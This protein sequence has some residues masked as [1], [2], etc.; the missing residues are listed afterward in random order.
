MTQ[1]A[2]G[3]LPTIT[4]VANHAGV[5]RATTSRALSNYGVVN[6]ATRAR[7]LESA[8]E[9]GYVPNVLARSMRAGSTH[10][11]GLIIAEVGLSVFDLAMRS[12]IESARLEDYQVLV[13]N[14]NEDLRAERTSVR[15]MLEKQVDGLIVVPSSV[16]ELEFLSKADLKGKPVTLL[17]RSLDSLGIASVTAD[18]LQG[19]RDAVEHM[20]ALGHT[21][22]GLIVVTAN[23]SGETGERP[24]GLITTIHDRVEGYYRAMADAGIDIDPA[25]VRYCGDAD[26]SATQA[27][28]TI[29][30]AENPPTAL[31]ASNANMSLAVLRVAKK[32]GLVIGDDLSLVGF[33]DAPWAAVLTPALTVV[34]L[35]IE[36][37]AKAAVDNLLAQIR[38]PDAE[39]TSV[40]LPTRLLIRDSVRDLSTA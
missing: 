15:V 5:S 34:D 17:D 10:T 28:N 22:I 39:P 8:A 24:A 27:V 25:W 6:A 23:L 18:N 19:T 32:R 36:Q 20:Q 4:D 13:T 7:V 29:L 35:P 37:M 31:I 26:E 21:K 14:T 9:L 1:S 40:V 11:L 30:D 33:D 2:K 38:N 3:A 12:V 16:D